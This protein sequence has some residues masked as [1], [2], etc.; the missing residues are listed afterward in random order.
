IEAGINARGYVI[1]GNYIH[2]PGTSAIN[3]GGEGHMITGNSIRFP[4]AVTGSNGINLKA[5]STA[6]GN[7]MS[8]MARGIYLADPDARA[9]G[10]I[11]DSPT[12]YGIY[13]RD[14]APR[15]MVAQNTVIGGTRGIYNDGTTADGIQIVNNVVSGSTTDNV[16]VI[17][18]K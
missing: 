9:I 11:I 14:T 7:Y 16:T 5:R 6:L 3:V 1:N 17:N 15:S 2:A 4:T 18:T 12:Q 13:V 8:G 10:N